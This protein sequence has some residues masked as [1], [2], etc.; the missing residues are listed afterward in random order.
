MKHNTWWNWIINLYWPWKAKLH[1]NFDFNLSLYRKKLL[2]FN[3]ER[4][5]RCFCIKSTWIGYLWNIE[6]HGHCRNWNDVAENASSMKWDWS[7]LPIDS[8]NS[9]YTLLLPFPLERRYLFNRNGTGCGWCLSVIIF[10]MLH[11]KFM[12]IFK[13]ISSC[14]LWSFI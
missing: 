7:S 3:N 1:S 4:V 9:F 6:E 13:I 10:I 12:F 2:Y 14:V 5:W 11:F 8:I